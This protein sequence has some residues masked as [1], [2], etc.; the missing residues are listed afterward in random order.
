VGLSLLAYHV[1]HCAYPYL[2]SCLGNFFREF[3]T[4]K[5]TTATTG[6]VVPTTLSKLIEDISRV[7]VPLVVSQALEMV[8][9][10]KGSSGAARFVEFLFSA[11]LTAPNFLELPE[12]PNLSTNYN[13][14]RAGRLAREFEKFRRNYFDKNSGGGKRAT[15]TLSLGGEAEGPTGIFATWLRASVRPQHTRGTR[16][17]LFKKTVTVEELGEAISII[18]YVLWVSRAKEEE[19]E[20][21]GKKAEEGEAEGRREKGEGRRDGDEDRREES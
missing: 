10:I 11:T 5:E 9:K 1:Q 8:H 16:T 2:S 3:S 4:V 12:F 19:Q 20:G 21:R 6:E 15:A 13:Y 18:R 7:P 14:S 17:P